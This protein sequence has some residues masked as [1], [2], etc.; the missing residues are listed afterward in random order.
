[1]LNI[2]EDEPGS[3]NCTAPVNCNVIDNVHFWDQDCLDILLGDHLDPPTHSNTTVNNIDS[4][5]YNLIIPWRNTTSHTGNQ[6]QTI[7]CV[8]A[9]KGRQKFCTTENVGLNFIGNLHNI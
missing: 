3:F 5:T 4:C 2:T 1:M 6:L 7:H 9:N 8:F